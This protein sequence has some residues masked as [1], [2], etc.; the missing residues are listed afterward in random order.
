[1]M[2]QESLRP[3]RD[4]ASLAALA[5]PAPGMTETPLAP[6]LSRIF[7]SL[8]PEGRQA[9]HPPL[10]LSADS[11]IVSRLCAR[12]AEGRHDALAL[13]ELTQK[14]ADHL[15]DDAPRRES[16]GNAGRRTRFGI[17]DAELDI[18]G[19]PLRTMFAVRAFWLV[20]LTLFGVVTSNLVAAQEEMLSHVIVLAAF[21][22]PIVDMGGNAG[23]Q[24]ATLVIRAMALGDVG[25]CRRDILRIIR[26][27]LPVAAALGLVV[28]ALESALA[29]ISKGIGLNV[30][31]VVGL[32]MLVC[33]VLGGLIGALLPLAAR[34]IGTDPA[35]LSSPLITSIMDL[36]GVCVYFALACAFLG[37]M[38]G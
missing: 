34:R 9:P 32:S 21:I 16:A 6:G 1:M 11:E 37:D 3:V 22:A 10:I 8:P 19:T 33:T 15:F 5:V 4:A 20:L 31:L 38:A 14:A 25:L 36:V 28:A 29:G 26:R 2:Y 13:R 30:L 35:T 7:A 24:S 27:E 17:D 12:D 18:L 23:S